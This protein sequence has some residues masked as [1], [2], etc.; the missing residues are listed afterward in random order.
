MTLALVAASLAT[1]VAQTTP[2]EQPATQPE[3]QPKAR[4][5]A[6]LPKSENTEPEFDPSKPSLEIDLLDYLSDKTTAIS[7]V[8]ADAI[9]EVRPTPGFRLVQVPV[10]VKP[11][12]AEG[13]LESSNLK[14]R[15]GRFLTWKLNETIGRSEKNSS[16]E[17][18]LQAAIP[19]GAPTLARKITIT[20]DGK[21]KWKLDRFIPNG[22]VKP[23]KRLYSYKLDPK[24][25]QALNPPP[26][27]PVR[28]AANEDPRT[29]QARRA[30]LAE[31][32]RKATQYYSELSKQVRDLPDEFEAPLPTRIWAV[33]ELS[34]AQ[35]EM[36]F[37]GAPPLPWRIVAHEFIEL[38]RFYTPVTVITELQPKAGL[39][40]DKVAKPILP[41]P[42]IDA[43]ARMNSIAAD[44]HPYNLRLVSYALAESRIVPLAQPDDTLYKLME[45][46]LQSSDMTSR[47]IVFKQLIRTIPP[48]AASL[49]LSK[50][51]VR[52]MDPSTQLLSLAGILKI[53]R[54][55]DAARMGETAGEVNR[56]LADPTGPPARDVARTMLDA[57][58]GQPTVINLLSQQVR[59]DNLPPDRFDGAAV[60]IIE[61]APDNTL[62]QTLLNTRLLGATDPRLVLRTLQIL[63]AAGDAA[64]PVVSGSVMDKV[65][66]GLFG[67][68]DK[69]EEKQ[70]A[71]PVAKLT[72]LIPIDSPTH[73]LF[74]AMQSGNS[75]TR[76]LAWQSVPHFAFI[77]PSEA[78]KPGA[79]KPA[80]A[81]AANAN[82]PSEL[83][84]ALLD[85]ALAQ[86]PT[87]PQVIV[88]LTAQS[89]PYRAASSV[90]RLILRASDKTSARGT[91]VLMQA[92]AKWPIDRA[93][94]ALS[95]GD[96]AAFAA[97]V[98]AN[99]QGTAPYVTDLLRQ[100]VE[101]N[102]V[103]AWFG[104]E[105]AAGRLPA[106]TVWAAQY[107]NK[108]TLLD[109]TV[110][111]DQDLA[112]AAV[113]AMIAAAGGEDTDVP[114]ALAQLR[115]LPDQNTPSL[116]KQWPAIERAAVIRRVQRA[117]GNYQVI[118][119][120]AEP[121]TRATA[122]PAP[123]D[124]PM[125]DLDLG[126]IQLVADG[127]TIRLVNQ[128]LRLSIQTSPAA[129]RVEKPS[130]LVDFKG[131]KLTGLRLE[132]L[133]TP[134]KLYPLD[135]G[136]W[137]GDFVLADQRPAQLAFKRVN[138]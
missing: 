81:V 29:F 134:F 109:L 74:R 84:A 54:E 126:A 25:L 118:L 56:L 110:S 20:P 91:T 41:K 85:A 124:I 36:R 3:T 57:A 131:D 133:N 127:E 6:T 107:T 103:A 44:K 65:V 138:R 125:T 2:D 79:G 72:K 21:V 38:Q 100:R 7:P 76:D 15:G 35:S 90:I 23:T 112:R 104:R 132:Q 12:K 19:D 43:V 97:R 59:L 117:V 9:W 18:E 111:N 27:P 47:Q 93:V 86:S 116:R 45:M 120:V 49:T 129:I 136:S 106:P 135:D 13:E 83:H 31:N 82:A 137:R 96:K 94:L 22:Y 5:A 51:V 32:Y 114:E 119:R 16:L 37:E 78:I 87:P 46:I 121:G 88:P 60:S 67:K 95:F 50:K 61:A 123:T 69:P 122:A 28:R 11:G 40:V 58:K 24:L 33:F 80:P 98:Y 130:E 70:S 42:V 26:Q 68:T 55:A 4:P 128:T 8:A 17:A 30:T 99:V 1:A 64:A 101:A 115:K 62:A 66:T 53:D 14:L 39:G 71:V 73:A 113:A 89:N 63:A 34:A 52:D 10:N 105:L 108:D 75:Q 48:T 92:G 102:P 77:D